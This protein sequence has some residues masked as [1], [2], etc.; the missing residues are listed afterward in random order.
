MSTEKDATIRRAYNQ[1]CRDNYADLAHMIAVWYRV[2]FGR[3]DLDDNPTLLRGG[4]DLLD[5]EALI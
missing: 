2:E 1:A 3:A 4:T 5:G